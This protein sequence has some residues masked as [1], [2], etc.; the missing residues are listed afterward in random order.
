MCKKL[1]EMSLLELW[2]RFPILLTAHIDDWKDWFAGEK[3]LL[4]RIFP[5]ERGF[6]ISHIGSTAIAGIWAKPIVDILVE[7]PNSGCFSECKAALAGA[8]YICMSE[9]PLRLSFNKGYTEQGYAEQVFH[10]HLRRNGDH[11][12][13]YFRD[14]LN[15]HSD[16]AKEYEQLKLKLW[17]Q[18]A[19]DRDGYTAQKSNFV[20]AVTAK[21]KAEFKGRYPADGQDI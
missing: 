14:Y 9:Q 8:G 5:A 12:E 21:A 6:K 7:A 15:A 19:Y 16:A 18:Y 3:A 1:S 13:L 17:K 11:D 4:L 2:R 20:A 10:L